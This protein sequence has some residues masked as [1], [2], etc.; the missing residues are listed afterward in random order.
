MSLK[1]TLFAIAHEY[2]VEQTECIAIRRYTVATYCIVYAD[3]CNSGHMHT[4]CTISIIS[5]HTYT[6]LN[7]WIIN[8]LN[9]AGLYC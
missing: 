3:T 7:T 8:K 4:L 5:S 2:M 9:Y 1:L 6:G